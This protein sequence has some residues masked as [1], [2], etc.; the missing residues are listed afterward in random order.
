MTRRMTRR[1]FLGTAAT[2]AGVAA[3]GWAG[4]AHLLVPGRPELVL[5]SEL[6][7]PPRPPMDFGP[8][9]EPLRWASTT[10]CPNSRG[11]PPLPMTTGW[12][13]SRIRSK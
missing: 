1:G 7:L 6:P 2:V 8:T 4:G 3:A 11:F 9:A 10:R 12:R 13:R 5:P